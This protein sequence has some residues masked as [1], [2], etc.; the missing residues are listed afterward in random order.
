[1]AEII[2]AIL[3]IATILGIGR[4]FEAG[5]FISENIKKKEDREFG[6]SCLFVLIVAIAI[7]A[8]FISD[9]N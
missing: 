4:L 8:A 1:M 3:V 9:L 7:I 2:V 5:I 6:C